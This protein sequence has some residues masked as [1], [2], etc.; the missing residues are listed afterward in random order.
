MTQ[1]NK[2]IQIELDKHLQKIEAAFDADAIAIY[3]IIHFGLDHEVKNA[4]EGLDKPARKNRLVVLV[5]TPG[6]VVQVVER[7][8]VAIRHFYNEVYFVIPDRAMSAGTIFAMSGDKIFMNYFSCLGPIDPQIEVGGALI[9]AMSYLN[10]YEDLKAKSIDGKLSQAEYVLLDKLDLGQLYEF[11]QARQLSIDLLEKWLSTYKFKEWIKTKGRG[12][13]VTPEM[14]AERAKSV[15]KTLSDNSFW[16]SHG[17]G[18]DMG[19]LQS[20]GIKLK[21]DDLNADTDKSRAVFEYHEL[22]TDFIRKNGYQWFVHTKKSSR[23]Q[24]DL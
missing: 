11:D 9:S 18:I 22:L 8:V 14:K 23:L 21:I 16:H 17:R 12:L 4:V 24:E 10:Q 7:M 13:D 2:C 5:D 15:A 3:G 19:T 20:D 6:G 1:V